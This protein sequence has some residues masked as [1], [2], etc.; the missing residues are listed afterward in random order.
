L[1][2]SSP[3]GERT[4][5]AGLDPRGC[6]SPRRRG[7]R[8]LLGRASAWE[9]ASTSPTFAASLLLEVIDCQTG[10]HAGILGFAGQA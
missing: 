10:T 8:D 7:E 9:V 3:D 2:V 6:S 1:T 4:A 5:Y